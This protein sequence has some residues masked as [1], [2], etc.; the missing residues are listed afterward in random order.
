[1]SGF[2]ID[3]FGFQP[4]RIKA[5]AGFFR[6]IGAAPFFTLASDAV[7]VLPALCCMAKTRTLFGLAISYEELAKTDHRLF[8]NWRVEDLE[9]LPV[10]HS[11]A[12]QIDM[13]VRSV[14]ISRLLVCHR[15]LK[16]D[17]AV[18]CRC[19]QTSI[20]A[21]LISCWRPFC[22]TAAPTTTCTCIGGALR[23]SSALRT[24]CSSSTTA[25]TAIRRSCER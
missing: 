25:P 11:L 15:R 1:M 20:H 6:R 21:F 5:I 23:E 22:K 8:E 24:E 12:R 16:A 17:S 13:L 10:R 18:L 3:E 4:E 2:R 7:S 14:L 9:A 19:L